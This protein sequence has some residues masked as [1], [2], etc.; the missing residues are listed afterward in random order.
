MKNT[1]IGVDLAKEVI[2]VCIYTN[3]KV[4]SNKEMTHNEFL[5]WL[6][7]TKPAII[8]FE[9]CGT[10]NYWKQKA[11]EAGHDARLISAKL[12][13]TVRQNQKTDK[14]DALAIVQAAQLPEIR[15]IKGKSEEQQQLQSV[16]R[17][18][19]LAIKQK[20]AL[21]NQLTALLLEFNLRVSNKNSGLKGLIERELEDAENGFSSEFRQALEIAWTQYAQ[22]LESIRVYDECLESSIKEHE[23]CKRLLK[24]E[25]VGTVNAINLF[26][27]LG[28]ANLGTFSKGKDASACIGL[29]PLQHSSGGKMKLGSIGKHV[30]NSLL[31]SQLIAGATSAIQQIVKREPVTK[32]EKW[33]QDLVERKGKKCAAV[34]LANKTV[35]TAFAMLTQGTEYKVELLAA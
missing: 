5:H 1:M 18:R 2:Q 29:T 33:I 6:F 8:I 28:C 25:G 30:K 10:S 14:N 22:I 17:L 9:A 23:E 4:Q 24:L 13:A 26:I 3:K 34:A 32:K 20:T 35:R 19:D 27:A 12:V 21:N 16:Q 15:F 31:R 11:I 7:T